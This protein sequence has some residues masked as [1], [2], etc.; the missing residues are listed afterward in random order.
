MA[1]ALVGALVEASGAPGNADRR[2]ASTAT[3]PSTSTLRRRHRRRAGPAGLRGAG[4]AR[5][6]PRARRSPFPRPAGGGRRPAGADRRAHRC[7]S[8]WR[9]RGSA[10]VPPTRALRRARGSDPRRPGRRPT[11]SRPHDDPDPSRRVAR[12]ILQR[13]D[14]MGKWG[15][16]HTDFTHLA[17]GFAG[18]DRAWP[19]RWESAAA[20]RPAGREAERRTAPRLPQPAACRRHPR[21]HRARRPPG[22]PDPA[23]NGSVMPIARGDPLVP[24]SQAMSPVQQSST[25][26]ATARRP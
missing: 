21:A 6:P 8:R 9:S 23:L 26:S 24:Y 5:R 25:W 18:N 2:A 7:S 17:R 19:R 20:R 1:A 13:L 4:R 12:R 16:Y 22:R 15:G 10:A 14:G 11:A 3:S